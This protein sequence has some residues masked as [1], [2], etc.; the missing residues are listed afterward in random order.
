MSKFIVTASGWHKNTEV[1]AA[2]HE[3]AALKAYPMLV[4]D[5]GWLPDKV[6]ARLAGSTGHDEQ[7]FFSADFPPDILE[8]KKGDLS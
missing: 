3:A 8:P 7:E 2:T 1:F 4:K 6:W 5:M